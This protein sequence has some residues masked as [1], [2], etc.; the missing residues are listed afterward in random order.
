M[1]DYVIGAAMVLAL[2]L[3]FVIFDLVT[4]QLHKPS[5]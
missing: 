2:G 1:P 3:A 5:H 4:R